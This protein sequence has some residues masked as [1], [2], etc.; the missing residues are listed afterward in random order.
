M[1]TAPLRG[2]ASA[3]AVHATVTLPLPVPELRSTVSHG[4]V[5][6]AVH[7]HDGADAVTTA[8]TEPWLAAAAWLLGESVNVQGGGGG[9]SPASCDT[10]TVRPA[11]VT[12]PVRATAAVLGSE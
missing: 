11:I 6:E 3:F 1:V 5:D 10:V 12:V 9:A 4:T 8:A 2:D 7:A